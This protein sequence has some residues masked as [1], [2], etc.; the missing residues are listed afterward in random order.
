MEKL[1]SLMNIGKEMARKLSAVGIGT[2]EQL[3]QAGRGDCFGREDVLYLGQQANRR[4]SD[5]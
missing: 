2:P 5:L 1:T 4:K 3:E